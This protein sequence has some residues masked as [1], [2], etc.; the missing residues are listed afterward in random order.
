M[1]D[2]SALLDA[3]TAQ[4]L[5]EGDFRIA[6]GSQDA[7]DE[8]SEVR[9]SYTVAVPYLDVRRAVAAV[10]A[11]EV[12]LWVRSAVAR[13]RLGPQGEVL[14]ARWLVLAAPGARIRVVSPRR[15]IGVLTV[16]AGEVRADADTGL[17]A[18][19]GHLIEVTAASEV[20]A[21]VDY[22]L[23]HRADA[24]RNLPLL[25]DLGAAPEHW[26]VHDPAEV[27]AALLDSIG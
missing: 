18:G 6:R 23:E 4:P 7:T 19:L 27:A 2:L 24:F 16:H 12:V 14:A 26:H 15:S 20:L 22:H 13:K 5:L 8:F 11:G 3:L 17:P 10:L 21:E 25:A 1:N 9:F